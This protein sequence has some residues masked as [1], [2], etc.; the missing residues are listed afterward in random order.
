MKRVVVTGIAGITSLGE[1]WPQI[2][3]NLKAGAT[4][5][6]RMPEWDRYAE[7]NTRLGGPELLM[8]EVP[9]ERL[10]CLRHRTV[11]AAG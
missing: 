9:E 5:I 2:E 8:T 4:G 11:H 10:T 6:E 7:L 3:A 1:T